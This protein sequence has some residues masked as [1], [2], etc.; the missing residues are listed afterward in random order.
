MNEDKTNNGEH[1]WDAQYDVRYRSKGQRARHAER[2][3][4][5]FT[6][7]ALPAHYSAIMAVLYHVKMRLGPSWSIQNIIDWG[8]GAGSGLWYERERVI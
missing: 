8:A 6:S 3:G 5:A 7:V 4:T 1:G 2:D